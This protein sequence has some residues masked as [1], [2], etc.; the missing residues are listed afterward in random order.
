MGTPPFS[1]S[2]VNDNLFGRSG[3]GVIPSGIGIGFLGNPSPKTSFLMCLSSNWSKRSLSF[4]LFYVPSKSNCIN[5]GNFAEEK[6][7]FILND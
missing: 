7:P 4:G 3:A 5:T 2:Q 1:S 6:K